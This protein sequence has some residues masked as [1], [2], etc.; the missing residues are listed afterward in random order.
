MNRVQF[1]LEKFPRF[2]RVCM[3]MWAAYDQKYCETFNEHGFNTVKRP[4]R[5]GEYWTMS[6]EEFTWFVLKWSGEIKA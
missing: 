4:T 6:E 2:H 1:D 3:A 5:E